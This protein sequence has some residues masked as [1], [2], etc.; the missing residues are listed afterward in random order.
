MFY[1]TFYPYD[2]IVGYLE[3][4][5]WTFTMSWTNFGSIPLNVSAIRI[6]FDWGKNYTHSLSTPL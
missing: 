1:D 5:D 2:T 6:Y 3:E 4:T